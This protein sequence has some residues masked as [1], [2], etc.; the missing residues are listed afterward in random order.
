M[1]FSK[2]NKHKHTRVHTSLS[3]NDYSP[4]MYDLFYTFYNAMYIFFFFFISKM[5]YKWSRLFIHPTAQS[6]RHKT[7]CY[8]FRQTICA[9]PNEFRSK[10]FFG[11]NVIIIYQIISYTQ[12]KNNSTTPVGLLKWLTRSIKRLQLQPFPNI[13]SVRY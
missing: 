7:H 1:L 10:S 13:A 11:R 2:N 9:E 6:T 5:M 4:V 12:P 3:L 8:L